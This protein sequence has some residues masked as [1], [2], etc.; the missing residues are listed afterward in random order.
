MKRQAAGAAPAAPPPPGITPNFVNP[1]YIGGRVIII[2]AVFLGIALAC[3]F[4][5]MF[6]RIRI[7]R[8]FGAD[9][10]TLALLLIIS[11]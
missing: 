3:F 11:A 6:T 10:G 7:T 2:V 1:D 5:R 4:I 9:D 8:G